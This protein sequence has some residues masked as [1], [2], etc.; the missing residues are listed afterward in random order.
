MRELENVRDS[1][2]QIFSNDEWVQW[3][4]E[5]LLPAYTSEDKSRNVELAKFSNHCAICRNVNGCCFPKNN[6]IHYPLHPNC[7]C[8]LIDISKPIITAECREEKFIGYVFA[9]KYADNGK[10][11]LFKEWGFA[12]IDTEYLINEFVRQ[13]KQKYDN[14]DFKLGVLNEYGQRISIITELIR[15]DGK[16]IVKFYSGWMV[17]PNGNIKN[18]TPYGGEVK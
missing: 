14:G 2:L 13:A 8:Y 4:H 7:H 15:K 1:I 16:G 5:G 18:T 11:N 12:K 9:N 10:N 6:N 17:Y 3:I